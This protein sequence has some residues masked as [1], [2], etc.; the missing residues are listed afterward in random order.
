MGEPDIDTVIGKV[1]VILDELADAASQGSGRVGLSEL[2]RRTGLAKATVHRICGE[3][4]DWG[5]VERA[6]DA[7]RLGPVLFDLGSRVPGRR[8]FRDAALPFLGDLEAATAQ[9]VHL[10]VLDQGEVLYVERLPGRS[11]A[12]VPSSVAARLPLHC[13]ATGKCLLAFGPD[14][15]LDRVVTAGLV[16]LTT[17]SISDAGELMNHLD[18]VRETGVSYEKGEVV[19]D[20]VSVG[21]PVFG[22]WNRLAG[23]ISVT[24]DFDDDDI[25]R[26]TPL[27]RVTASALSRRLGAAVA[28]PGQ[29]AGG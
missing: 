8:A 16:P 22:A 11:T 20:L 18:Q 21:A 12:D 7:F 23:A 26:L 4:V 19:D 10:A 15:L 9:T 27:V 2:T 13:T 28:V 14:E 25:A 5:V 1:R 3:L 17:N 29:I 24:G 6:V